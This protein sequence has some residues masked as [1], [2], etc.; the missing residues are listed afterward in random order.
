MRRRYGIPD[1]DQRPFNVAYAAARLAQEDKRKI[2]DRM[3][4]LPISDPPNVVSHGQTRIGEIDGP[5][6]QQSVTPVTLEVSG[7]DK[8]DK[9]ITKR[10][11]FSPHTA[12]QPSR[13]PIPSDISGP[14]LQPPPRQTAHGHSRGE[15]PVDRHEARPEGDHPGHDS[16]IEVDPAPAPMRSKRMADSSDEGDIQYSQESR[17]DKRRRKVSGRHLK[18]RMQKD[19]DVGME[20]GVSEVRTS[21]N[22]KK[23]DHTEVDSSFGID[24]DTLYNDE[25][26]DIALHR[27]RKRRQRKSLNALRGQKRGRDIDSPGVDTDSGDPRG[28]RKAFR[29]RPDTSDTDLSVEEGQISRDPLCK[30][31]HIGEEWESHGVQFRVAPDGQRL[32]KVLVREDRPKFNMP[33]DS[34]HPDRSAS[35]TAIVE[36]W[37]T[38]EQHTAAKEAHELAW[39]DFDKPFA[40]PETPSDRIRTSSNAGKQLLWASTSNAGSPVRKIRSS[41]YSSSSAISSPRMVMLPLAP[42]PHYT[43]RVSSLYSSSVVNPTEMSPKLRPSKSYSKWEKQEIEAEAIARLRR[44]AEEKEKARA[45]AEA[46]EAEAKKLTTAAALPAP[47]LTLAK[48][49]EKPSA[50]PQTVASPFSLP[51]PKADAQVPDPSHPPSMFTPSSNTQSVEVKGKPETQT[52]QAFPGASFS[53]PPAPIPATQTS[54]STPAASGTVPSS[55]AISNLFAQPAPPTTAPSLAAAKN[56]TTSSFFGFGQAKPPANNP[57]TNVSSAPQSNGPAP[58]GLFSITQPTNPPTSIN[59]ST[60]SIASAPPAGGTGDASKP[61]FNFGIASKPTAAPPSNPV[62]AATPDPLR[63]VF[64]FGA[65]KSSSVPTMQPP[66]NP[67]SNAST[68]STTATQVNQSLVFGTG[69]GK[70]TGLPT[71]GATSATSGIKP[72]ENTSSA[73]R[74]QPLPTEAAAGGSAAL[75]G[76]PSGGA[77]AQGTET[78]NLKPSPFAPANIPATKSPFSFGVPETG[79]GTKSE[80]MK[81]APAVFTFAPAAVPP[82]PGSVFSDS[83]TKG[84]QNAE[85]ITQPSFGAPKNP[86]TGTTGANA[87]TFNPFGQSSAPFSFSS[88]G[89]QSQKS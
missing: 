55:S 3:R 62:A 46:K 11:P 76:V 58:Q 12:G 40:E 88:F 44:K 25:D 79:S 18:K 73:N 28:K 4:N 53:F 15:E 30:G 69:D 26:H 5:E 32:R 48:P 85:P 51:T 67:F 17:H 50:V 21:R 63:P 68:A 70:P 89:P 19:D 39:Q 2:Q 65:P 13:V 49:D 86:A 35:V 34:E 42:P 31:R 38:E 66:A 57:I 6:T 56:S 41:G 61:K 27:Q 84:S 43:R 8:N 59:T 22:S 75:F 36:R 20:N 37:Y 60:N 64:S 52:A 71:S 80:P 74:G 24:D 77:K 47:S 54:A 33:V 29:H 16:G 23:R 14:R 82:T 83:T 78:T 87:F 45:E 9:P 72:G 81:T 10:L 1:H 7:H